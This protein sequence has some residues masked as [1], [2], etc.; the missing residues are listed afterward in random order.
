VQFYP[1]GHECPM[2]D[3]QAL[4]AGSRQGASASFCREP[5]DLSSGG[6]DIHNRLC[7]QQI[8]PAVE[9]YPHGHECHVLNAEALRDGSREGA[10]VYPPAFFS[11]SDNARVMASDTLILWP[12]AS[13]EL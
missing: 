11:G 13:K 6:L 8:L 5:D 12:S 9:F 3:A 4:R 10:L 1:H 2:L 7:L